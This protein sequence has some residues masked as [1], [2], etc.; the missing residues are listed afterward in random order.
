VGIEVSGVQGYIFSTGKLKEMVGASQII[1]EVASDLYEEAVGLLALKPL[2]EPGGEGD[3]IVTLRNNAGALRALLPSRE[4][5]QKFLSVFSGLAL[6]RWP[7]LPLNGAMVNSGFDQKS[8]KEAGREL[9]AQ[10]ESRRARCPVP[11]GLGLL[12]PLEMAPLDGLPAAGRDFVGEKATLVS[13]PS[14]V[15]RDKKTIEAADKRLKDEFNGAIVGL[16]EQIGP[17]AITWPTGLEPKWVDDFDEMLKGKEKPRLALIHL[18]A[19]DLGHMMGGHGEENPEANPAEDIQGRKSKS[20]LIDKFNKSSFSAALKAAI[21]LDLSKN[22][23]GLSPGDGPYFIP[24]RPLVIGGDDVT[25]IVRA[26]L[27][28]PFVQAFIETY[29]RESR[30]ANFPLSLGAGMLIMPPSYPFAKARHLTEELISGA[31]KAGKN[32]GTGEPRPSGLD[33]LVISAD[34]EDDLEALRARTAVSGDGCSLTAKPFVLSEGFLESF[35]KNAKQ[36]LDSL[37]RSHTRGALNDCRR[38]Q[39]ESMP[40]YLKLRE[41]ILRKF[42]GRFDGDLLSPEKFDD[43]FPPEKG[44]FVSRP[45]E[46]RLVTYLAYYLELADLI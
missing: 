43:I 11:K 30:A 23:Q 40:A 3:W 28:F 20:A 19:N 34:V 39:A 38:G 17:Q 41:N 27:A 15:K 21:A 26:D 6:E 14:I 1:V 18:D 37:P 24:L 45:D 35:L 44:F 8:L 32:A 46:K 36:V 7:G 29:E 22:P 13:W 31:K 25:V 4:M 16:S 9:S 12:P 33:Y 10:I 2:P 42:G 5:G